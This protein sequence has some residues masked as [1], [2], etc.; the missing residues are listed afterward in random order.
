MST[1]KEKYP[2]TKEKVKKFI[3]LGYFDSHLGEICKSLYTKGVFS[4]EPVCYISDHN[5]PNLLKSFTQRNKVN[6]ENEEKREKIKNALNLYELKKHNEVEFNTGI[7]KIIKSLNNLNEDLNTKIKEIKGENDEFIQSFDAYKEMNKVKTS[8][9]NKKVLLDLTANYK[10][11]KNFSF[12]LKSLNSDS[13]KDSPL[14]ITKKDK[15]CF[16]YILNRMRNNKNNKENNNISNKKSEQKEPIVWNQEY[17]NNLKEMKFLKKVDKITK[18]KIWK[19]NFLFNAGKEID[20][21]ERKEKIGKLEIKK[22]KNKNEYMKFKENMN[23]MKEERKRQKL[24]IEKDKKEINKIKITINETFGIKHRNKKLTSLKLNIPN[25]SPENISNNLSDI[26]EQTFSIN[27][28]KFIP[29]SMKNKKINQF[30]STMNRDNLFN[31]SSYSNL[32]AF[33]ESIIKHKSIYSKESPSNNIFQ[34]STYYSNSTN[35]KTENKTNFNNLNNINEIYRKITKKNTTKFDRNNDSFSLKRISLGDIHNKRKSVFSNLK[36]KYKSY[37]EDPKK[38]STDNIYS[39]CK[40]IGINKSTKNK[41]EYLNMIGNY[42]KSKNN[43]AFN[44]NKEFGL[45]ETFSF[46]H[47]I[48]NKIKDT[49]VKLSFRNL[50]MKEQSEGRKKLKYIDIL[51]SNLV[52]KENELLY[53]I[54]KR[55]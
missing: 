34:R 49:D 50:K 16:Y 52:N 46:F 25:Y 23:K 36:L 17:M 3:N 29:E 44:I 6:N 54:I 45:K 7:F 2:N 38:H 39:I 37:L 20:E 48:K 9:K 53:K 19:Y 21:E 51:D 47:K 15:L 4:K 35:S 41:K 11:D 8:L 28:P 31:S 18:N 33:N 1:P 42:I 27:R 43:V 22:F 14:S 32:K 12:N 30:N 10:P 55:K 40:K 13:F 24:E 5:L 26:K